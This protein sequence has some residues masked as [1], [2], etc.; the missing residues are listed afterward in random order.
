MYVKK[1]EKNLKK[2]II[3]VVALI[4]CCFKRIITITHY[5]IK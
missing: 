5:C 4:K 2:K 3:N 1:E